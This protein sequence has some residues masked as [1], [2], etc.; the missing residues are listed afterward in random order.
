[1][2]DA[3]EATRRIERRIAA[4]SA[5]HMSD[6]KWRKLFAALHSFPGRLRGAAIKFVNDDRMFVEPLPGPKFKHDDNLGE[7]G[8]ISYS[9]FAHIEFVQ[10]P[11]RFASSPYGPRY[12]E[13]VIEND[14]SSLV[15]FL[16]KLGKF[17]IESC[18]E[19]IRVVGY[20]WK[21]DTHSR[22]LGR[23]S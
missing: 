2:Y 17:P 4:A 22:E 18:A 10:I 9:R 5:A 6:A 16:N 23:H 12:P 20:S 19:G 11:N 3:S 1:M 21:S 8:G 14:L 13:T 7:C 15:D